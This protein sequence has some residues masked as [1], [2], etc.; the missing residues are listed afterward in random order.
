MNNYNIAIIG[1]GNIGSRHLQA[2][3]KISFPLN[4]FVVDTK[5]TS[6]EVALARYNEIPSKTRHQISYLGTMTGLPKNLDIVIVATNSNVRRLVMEKVLE[7]STVKYFVL[8]K[9][10]FPNIHDY[11]FV[12][13]LLAKHRSKAWVNCSM[14]TIP[15]Y[16]K[17][18]EKFTGFPFIYT[19]TGSQYGLVTNSIHYID[20]MALLSGCYDF[21]VNTSGLIAKIYPSKRSGYFE[22]NGILQINFTDN[23]TGNI[24]CYQKGD[25]P[26]LI[27]IDSPQC[28]VVSIENEGVALISQKSTDYKWVK[29]KFQLL[30]QSEMTDKIVKD[31]LSRGNCQLTPYSMS[32]KLHVELIKALLA[33]LKKNKLVNKSKFPFT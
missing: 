18:T 28:R 31:L 7:K 27:S 29:Q 17:M 14:R 24:V 15:F 12:E 2:L 13:K 16:F 9:L 30:Y 22:L 8:E 20:H 3:K 10:L 11:K 1:V 32:A 6:L 19:V 5:K 25:A 23:I 21:T 33:F 4:I 26:V